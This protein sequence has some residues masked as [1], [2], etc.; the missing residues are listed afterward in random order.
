MFLSEMTHSLCSP[1]LRIY[2]FLLITGVVSDEEIKQFLILLDP[3]DFDAE[4]QSGKS[5]GT[6]FTPMENEPNQKVVFVI[7]RRCHLEYFDI[8]QRCTF[9]KE[10]ALRRHNAKRPR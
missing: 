10:R 5:Y 3:V 9:V 4:Y 1:L 2:N 6:C 7:V 8:L